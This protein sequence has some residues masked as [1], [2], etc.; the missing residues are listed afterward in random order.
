MESGETLRGFLFDFK[1]KIMGMIAVN[2]D[3]FEINQNYQGVSLLW[4]DKERKEFNTGDFVKDWYDC[5]FYIKNHIQDEGFFLSSSCTDFLD[6]GAPYDMAY[7]RSYDKG[8]TFDLKYKYNE[9]NQGDIFFVPKGEKPTWDE[10]IEK[11]V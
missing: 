7:L 3:E 6:D 9:K 10:F 4:G 2:Y 5:S 11:Y 8:K 1:F